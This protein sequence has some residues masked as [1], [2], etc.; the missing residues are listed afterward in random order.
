[1]NTLRLEQ[2]DSYQTSFSSHVTG[3]ETR[4]NS[5]WISLAESLFYP[6]SGGQLF[7]TGTLNGVG[8]TDV[9]KEGDEVWHRVEAASFELGQSVKGQIDWSRRYHHMQ[10]HS[11]QHLLSQAFCAY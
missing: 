3:L 8:V 2:Q 1:M 5:L 4:D 9:V 11:A 10:R 6:T 7:D